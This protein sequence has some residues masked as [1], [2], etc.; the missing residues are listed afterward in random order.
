MNSFLEL[1]F[2]ILPYIAAGSMGSAIMF[3]AYYLI[4]ILS[5]GKED[6]DDHTERKSDSDE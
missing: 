2:D 1:F 4:I 6:D 3:A 5:A